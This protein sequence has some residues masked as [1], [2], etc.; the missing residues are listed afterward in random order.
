MDAFLLNERLMM[1]MSVLRLPEPASSLASTNSQN[2]F[3]L[4]IPSSNRPV[5]C[6]KKVIDSSLLLMDM[7]EYVNEEDPGP[8]P[9][10]EFIS[11]QILLDWV[12]MVE[13]GDTECAHLVLVSLSYLLDFLI[14]V[15]FLG[16]DQ[17]K[18]SV[19]Q[20]IRDKIDDSNWLEVFKYT[21][22]IMGLETT[23]KDALNHLLTK[24]VKF[25]SDCEMVKSVQLED[26]FAVEYV[27][28]DPAMVKLLLKSQK[29]VSSNVKFNIISRWVKHHG[30]P[31]DQVA[32]FDLLKQIKFKDL[33]DSSIESITSEVLSWNLTEEQISIFTDMVDE[34]KKERDAENEMRKKMRHS[35]S[36]KLMYHRGLHSRIQIHLGPGLGHQVHHVLQQHLWENP[37]DNGEAGQAAPHNN[38]PVALAVEME[39]ERLMMGLF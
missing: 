1:D 39:E 31:I 10:P 23:T 29:S 4:V 15:D 6:S 32:V 35:E 33:S 19:E 28:L 16:C 7:L 17:I 36:H 37:L 30:F 26:P 27:G 3:K 18:L 24:I 14:A 5:F 21:R 34:A 25:Y 38:L 9:M 22:G 2:N 13:K 8:I 11:R 20:K 12:E